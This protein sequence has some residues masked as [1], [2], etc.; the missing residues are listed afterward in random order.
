MVE[1]GGVDNWDG[2]EGVVGRI[3]VW[4]R[5]LVSGGRICE[6]SGNAIDV[7]LGSQ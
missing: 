2:F 3:I 7:Y 1:R 6:D 5:G 4:D